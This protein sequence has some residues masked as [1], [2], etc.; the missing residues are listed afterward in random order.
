MGEDLEEQY[1]DRDA[2]VIQITDYTLGTGI[3]RASHNDDLVTLVERL[4]IEGL[5]KAA[6]KIFGQASTGGET[7]VDRG[8]LFGAKLLHPRGIIQGLRHHLTRSPI[9]LDLDQHE[10]SIG[11]YRQEVDTATKPGVLLASD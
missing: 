7:I 6:T 8:N 4:L 5:A 1:V 10:R 3:K 2:L 11:C 9:P